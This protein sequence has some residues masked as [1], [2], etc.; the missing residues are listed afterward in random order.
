M[1]PTPRKAATRKAATRKAATPATQVPPA[2]TRKAPPRKAARRKKQPQDDLM[3]EAD[4]E[5]VPQKKASRKQ[6]QPQDDS[7]DEANSEAEARPIKRMMM[8]KQQE[9]EAHGTSQNTR[10]AYASQRKQAMTWLKQQCKAEA[11]FD[12][13]PGCPAEVSS[14]DEY[15][16]ED[17]EHAFDEK[18]NR[19]S[20]VA[21]ALFIHWRCFTKGRKIG[22]AWQTQAAF[23]RYWA[24]ADS[25][26]LHTGPWVWHVDGDYGT[27]NPAESRE[28]NQ[29]VKAVQSRDA[30]TGERKHSAP[31]RK[32]YMDQIMAW[33]EKECPEYFIQAFH[34]GK[35][36]GVE[37]RVKVT[38]HLCMRAFSTSAFTLWAR[39]SELAQLQRK[40]YRRDLHTRDVHQWTYDECVLENR[41]GWQNKIQLSN[42]VAGQ[43]Y[44]IHPQHELPSLDM[45][46]HMQR[47]LSFLDRHIYT[48]VKDAN[49]FIFPSISA[50][51]LLHP[52]NPITSESIQKLIDEFLTG[53][54]IDMGNLKITTHGFRRGGAQYRFIYAPIG[55]RWNLNSCRWWGGWAEG[56]HKNTMVR[57]LLNEQYLQEEDYGDSLRP[58]DATQKISNLADQ[59]DL[60][61]VSAAAVSSI[62]R[63]E[64]QEFGKEI[65][66]NFLLSAHSIW[67]EV[68]PRRG[69]HNPV[70]D[71]PA[72]S[73]ALLDAESLPRQMED[74]P[75]S[76]LC[77]PSLPRRAKNGRGV[78]QLALDD[79]YYDDGVRN[80][81]ALK[82]WKASWRTGEYKGTFAMQY[83]NRKKIAE[84]YEQC[85]KDDELFIKTWPEASDGLAAL[86]MAIRRRRIENEFENRQ[87]AQERLRARVANFSC[88]AVACRLL[89][90]VWPCYLSVWEFLEHWVERWGSD[91]QATTAQPKIAT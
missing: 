7:T 30:A 11:A 49:D 56:E 91:V 26:G 16:L 64:L 74:K 28:V 1:A 55:K 10:V 4:S 37:A 73:G 23:L 46:T 88:A 39:N 61:P 34:S 15:S 75:P 32:E 5:P 59:A 13:P 14:S 31:M 62:V 90:L 38:K 50:N 63:Q 76:N 12:V 51:G 58:I 86:S 21:L 42:E 81:V 60:Q 71:I 17:F 72:S 80:P 48:D 24:D 68:L 85:N 83:S 29:I 22:I 40:H 52:G 19:T 44:E 87:F 8:K 41:K 9:Q 78:W 45:Y 70:P 27:G 47:W 69:D 43:R 89:H 2:A 6:K 82:D 20:A 18:P 84:E 36:L 77:I 67:P 66:N 53:A 3:D 25:N 57:Y 35:E 79:W 65:M 54:G 33:S